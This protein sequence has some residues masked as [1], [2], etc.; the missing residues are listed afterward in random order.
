MDYSGLPLFAYLE[1]VPA[2]AAGMPPDPVALEHP[3]PLLDESAITL[4]EIIVLERLEPAIAA[5]DVTLAEPLPDLP[6]PSSDDV[7]PCRR[8]EPLMDGSGATLADVIDF[9]TRDPA[10]TSTQRADRLCA[11]RRLAR[12]LGKDPR[13]IPVAPDALRLAFASVVPAAE[14]VTTG[15]WSTTRSRTMAA[16]AQAG[17]PVMAGRSRTKLPF[18]WHQLERAL[19]TPRAKLG[20]SRFMRFCTDRTIMPSDVDDAVF[21]RFREALQS[22]SL[23]ESPH[24]VHRTAC[25]QWNKAA[26]SVSGWPAV[27]VKLPGNAR[28]YSFA[29]SD[30]PASFVAD[31]ESFLGRSG[32]GGPFA[33]DYV[34]AQRPGTIQLQRRQ[35]QQMASHLVLSGVPI[36][37]VTS[38]AVLADLHHARTILEAAHKRL[39]T[40]KSSGTQHLHGMALLLKVIAQHWVKAPPELVEKLARFA[41]QAAPASRGMTDKNRSRLRQFDSQQNIQALLD[42]PRRVFRELKAKDPDRQDGLRALNALAIELLIAAPMRITNLAGLD[43]ARHLLRIGRGAGSVLHI[44]IPGN[45]TKTGEPF[46]VT[47]PTET[48]AL[49][50]TYRTRYLPLISTAP[51]PLL[52]PNQNGSL[53]SAMAFSRSITD[54]IKRETGL[55]MNVH[56]FRHAAVTLYLQS[57]PEDLET[58]RRILGHKSLNTTMR[59]YA[60]IKTT[61]S[62]RRYDDVINNLRSRPLMRRQPRALKRRSA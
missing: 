9:V 31:I 53:R 3:E 39:C 25:D 55:V 62:F 54:F 28:H 41:R 37:K 58:A 50:G 38:L 30:F 61:A 44:V 46:E 11:M 32:G 60:E 40:G 43:Q 17:I 14:G 34:R 56:L 6:G 8:P 2:V 47:V 13:L 29:W 26:Q 45:E 5:P 20:L 51:T 33:D 22:E 4:A 49:L 18:A 24:R 35:L 12:I 36:D 16:V 52:F 19:P 42:L 10:V 59:F 21:D 7:V 1:P 48:A 23:V 15:R 57:H 27:A